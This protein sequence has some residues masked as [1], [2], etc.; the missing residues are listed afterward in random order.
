MAKKKKKVAKKKTVKKKVAKKLPSQEA[1]KPTQTMIVRTSKGTK[2][3]YLLV[4]ALIVFLMGLALAGILY[5]SYLQ[6]PEREVRTFCQIDIGSLYG[7]TCNIHE[8]C[9]GRVELC[10][11]SAKICLATSIVDKTNARNVIIPDNQLE[12]ETNGGIWTTEILGLST[13]A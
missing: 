4:G 12:C 8:D 2:Q 9:Y 13:A 11:P 6:T 3:T 10:S 5:Q 7:K 1:K